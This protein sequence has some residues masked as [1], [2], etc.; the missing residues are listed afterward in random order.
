MNII[1]SL[2]TIIIGNVN[3]I[4]YD[5]K[6]VVPLCLRSISYNYYITFS[7]LHIPMKEHDIIMDEKNQI[8]GI[9][10]DRYFSIRT[11]DTTYDYNDKFWDS[12]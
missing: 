1:F 8:E 5:S 7:P 3:V 12:I 10:F 11:Q 2:G 6:D 9:E 4:C